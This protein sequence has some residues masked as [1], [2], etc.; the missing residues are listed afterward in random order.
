[1]KRIFD[2]LARLASLLYQKKFIVSGARDEYVLPDQLLD[3]VI[4]YMN[5]TL[6]NPKLSG[7]FHD[8]QLEELAD[9]LQELKRLSGQIPF[10]DELVTNEEL[11]LRN[12]YWID[13]RNLVSEFLRKSEF[14]LKA[15]EKINCS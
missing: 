1:M 6:S 5:T 9:L 14:D 10:N 7:S 13:V 3:E 4:A 15:W 8:K 2:I 12:Q 11:V